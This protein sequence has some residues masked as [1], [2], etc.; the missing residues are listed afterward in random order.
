M[1]LAQHLK[2]LF[3]PARQ[4][5][6]Q[7]FYRVTKFFERDPQPVKRFQIVCAALGTQDS[8]PD[9]GLVEGARQSLPVSQ[10]MS[11]IGKHASCFL[12]HGRHVC[13]DFAESRA[14]K[15]RAD[16]PDEATL[17]LAECL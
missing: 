6:L 15:P 10:P 11:W 9:K 5:R 13:L 16:L 1:S 8:D 2:F 3:N 17:T 12:A 14:A 7:Q 4:Q